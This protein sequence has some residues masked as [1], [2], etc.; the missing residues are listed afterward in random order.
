MAQSNEDSGEKQHEPSQKKLDDARKK[1]EVPLSQD[2]TTAGA[3]AGLIATA[4]IFGP[5][6]LLELGEALSYSL[7]EPA[8]SAENIF[9]S[10]SV[11]YAG[12]IIGLVAAPVLPW[13]LGPLFGVIVAVIAQRAFTTSLQK[14]APRLSRIS[15][16]SNAKQKFGPDGLFNFAKSFVKLVIFSTAL[17]LA[18]LIDLPRILVSPLGQA[19][20]LI[21]QFLSMSFDFLT[22]VL[23]VSVAVGGLDYLWQRAQHMKKNRMSHKELQEEVKESEGDPYLRQ[24]RRE[25][26]MEAATGQ[27]MADVPTANVVIVNPTHFAVALNWDRLSGGAPVC[28]AKGRDEVAKRIR[29]IAVEAGVPIRHDAPTARALFATLNV[30]D[31][32]QQEHYR[33]V[34]AAIRF[35]EEVRSRAKF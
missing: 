16:I 30:G 13:L 9:A 24:R 23:C 21:V 11:I 4:M 17:F 19:N 15:P 10:S 14:V 12:K 26:A 31:E 28:V 7:T 35:A 20:Q 27:M 34:A 33:P 6:S 22:V 32:V 8:L 25:K 29:D 3:Y 1:G 5:D 2:L 18:V